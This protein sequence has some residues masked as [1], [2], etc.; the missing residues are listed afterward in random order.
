MSKDLKELGEHCLLVPGERVVWVL[1]KGVGSGCSLP[2]SQ[3]QARLVERKVCFISDASNW[4]KG[5]G[6]A[7]I[8]PKT[9]SPLPRQSVGK[10]FYNRRRG[11]MQKQHGQSGH[12]WSDQLHLGLTSYHLGTVNL[13]FWASLVGQQVK[14]PLAMQETSV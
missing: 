4:R 10:C 3:N 11:Y 2:Q 6:R 14:N 5:T 12:W 7:D 13:Q 9:N 1:P 8:C